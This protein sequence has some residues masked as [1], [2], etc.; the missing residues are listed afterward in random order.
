[1]PKGLASLLRL[2]YIGSMSNQKYTQEP[3]KTTAANNG[4]GQTTQVFFKEYEV[5]RE[6]EYHYAGT[7]NRRH[8]VFHISVESNAK[9]VSAHII[10]K[11]PFN[12]WNIAFKKRGNTFTARVPHTRVISHSD[13]YWY[14]YTLRVFEYD[15]NGEQKG[16][17]DYKTRVKKYAEF[18]K[19][20]EPAKPS[21]WADERGSVRLSG[22]DEE[23]DLFKRFFPDPRRTR[24]PSIW[25]DER[26][27]VQLSKPAP[28]AHIKNQRWRKFLNELASNLNEHASHYLGEL[29]S[30]KN[31][32]DIKD[33]I[34]D[35]ITSSYY[36]EMM[37]MI[38]CDNEFNAKPTQID[39]IKAYERIVDKFEDD[40]CAK[41]VKEPTD[42]NRQ[43]V[44]D[45]LKNVIAMN[46]THSVRMLIEELEAGEDDF[47][48]EKFNSAIAK[49][50]EA[51][52]YC[53]AP[54]RLAGVKAIL[55]ELETEDKMATDN[56]YPFDVLSNL[57]ELLIMAARYTDEKQWVNEEYTDVMERN[58]KANKIIN[59]VVEHAIKLR[60]T[61]LMRQSLSDHSTE[62]NVAIEHLQQ[63][64][65]Y[66]WP[67]RNAPHHRSFEER[68]AR[69]MERIGFAINAL[70][71]IKK[72]GASNGRS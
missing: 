8:S 7:T 37:T 15:D 10:G 16:Y 43:A 58:R 41:Y 12:E 46:Q 14:V 22:D 35:Q 69:S 26:G 24:K 25:S 45:A 49:R 48:D 72:K 62:I 6:T 39:V 59:D 20:P 1:M 52:D 36:S 21:V 55:A 27:S 18:V 34:V 33:V 71:E 42:K 4:Q 2:C 63:A 5:K 53:D 13:G 28:H 70:N 19:M 17:T 61:L 31:A 30:A 32:D 47:T 11:G 65:N 38:K 60:A 44:K 68:I 57:T 64:Y 40:L 23:C 50:L 56:H 54:K 51:I 66:L 3:A 9:K 29:E 67:E